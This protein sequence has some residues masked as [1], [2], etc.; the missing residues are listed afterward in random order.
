MEIIKTRL[1][2]LVLILSGITANAQNINP[3]LYWQGKERTLRYTPDGEEFVITN[4]NKRFTRAIYGTNTGFRFE[5]SDFPEFGLYMP[6]LGGSVYMAIQ[7]PSQPVCWIKDMESVES[8]FKSGQRTY[9]LKDKTHLG[10]GSL[11]IDAV[12]LSDADGFIVKYRAENIPTGTKILWI[13]GG[14]SNERF[15]R[16]GDIGAD[17]SDSFYIKATNC[18]GNMYRIEDHA[19]TLFYGANTRPLSMDEAYENPKTL[20]KSK[21]NTVTLSDNTLQIKGVFPVGTTLREVDGNLIDKIDRLMASHPSESPVI[22]AQYTPSAEPFYIEFHNPKT[23]AAFSYAD[24][25]KAFDK[26]IEFRTKIASRMKINTPDPFINTLGGIYA[27]AEDAVWEDPGY[28]HGAIGWRVPLTGWRAAYLA[29]LMGLQDRARSHF[30]GYIHSQVSH[31]PVTLPHLQDSALHLARAAKIWGTPMYSNGYICRSPNNTNVMHHYDMNVVFID[32]LLWHLNWTGD[33]AYVKQVFPTIQ[34]HLAWEKNTFDP[35]NDGLYDAYCCIWASDALQYNGGKATHSTA[36][37][38]RANKL[39][40][41]LARKIGE[42]PTPYEKEAALILSAVNRELWIKEKGW[43][44]EFKDNMG[45]QM[46]HEEPA[47]WTFYHTVD[48]ELHDPFQAYQASRY[49]D[50]RLAN[51]PV[52][53]H[54]Y[55]DTTNYVVA[56]TNW[57]PYMWSINNVAFAETVHTALAY[58]QSGRTEEAYRM[59]KGAVLDAMYLGSGPGN[60]TQVSFYDAARGETYRDFADPV[61]MAVRATVQGMFGI[62]P[63]LTNKRLTV[64][65]G[66]PV[67]WDFADM[68][69]QNMKFGYKRKGNK[70]YYTISPLFAT[71]G[72]QLTLELKARFDRLPSVKV[73]GQSVSCESIKNLVGQPVVRIDA[74]QSERYEITVEWKGNPFTKETVSATVAQGDDISI[75]FRQTPLEVNDPQ[76]TLSTSSITSKNLKGK[77]VGLEGHR[78]VF[79]RLNLGDFTFWQPVQIEVKQPVEIKNNPDSRTLDIA[80]T[81]RR[82]KPLQGRIYLN[83][84]DT[85]R[86]INLV[87]GGTKQLS[88]DNKMATMGTNRISIKNRDE[89]IELKAINWNIPNVGQT[90]YRTVPISEA[91]NDKVSSIFEYGKYVSPRW[92]YTTLQVP[93]QGMGQWCHPTDLSKIDDT[94]LRAAS[95]RNKGVFMLPQGIPFLTPAEKEKNNILFTTLWDN[96]PSSATLPLHGKASKAYLFVAGSTYHMQAHVLNGTITVQYKDGSTDRLELVLPDN[97][98]PLDQDIFIDGWAYNSNQPRPWRIRLQNGRVSQY[99]AGELN[100]R[101]S[102]NPIYIEGGMATLLDL[103]LNKEKELSS[104]SIETIANEVI[105]GLMGVTLVE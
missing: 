67:A 91:F 3:A 95:E 2:F 9:I 23:H 29:D 96:Y 24:L 10:N 26:G 38:Y 56:T 28:L 34:R 66:L 30:D 87:S 103:P 50:T 21:K 54:N 55:A 47:L 18:K 43:W 59:Y 25:P 53:A 57:Q 82:H 22:I 48:S 60:I 64:R 51:I 69:T 89:Q 68:E 85:K 58:W 36:Y 90:K 15:S 73:N 93:T 105:I 86:D 14:A 12:A 44:A 98:L 17:P 11:T 100:K 84:T 72:I 62:I 7:T 27:G 37:N 76:G 71:S 88:F 42:D 49:I 79:V 92:E 80:L 39:A 52:V 65:P 6:N 97:L 19:F 1:L 40:A 75:A 70:D 104:L 94:G 45:H 99:H 61:S 102:N 41:E 63:D 83:G 81:N 5:T 31:V 8:R 13:Y 78:T 35:D 20:D 46:R 32:E 16:E 77:V 4:G 74:G 101:M 33:M